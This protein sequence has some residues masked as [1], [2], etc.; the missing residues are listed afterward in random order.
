M[1]K[2]S[3]ATT[4]VIADIDTGRVNYALSNGFAQKG[5]IVTPRR[6]SNEISEN[7]AAAKEIAGD[8]LQIA[9]LHEPDFEG[10][11]VTFDCTGKEICMQS[12]LYVRLTGPMYCQLLTAPR[13][14]GLADSL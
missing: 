5:Y 8:I 9:G 14:Q 2:L 13:R 3:G 10:A 11:D 12:G 1:A 4:V 6:H 7:L